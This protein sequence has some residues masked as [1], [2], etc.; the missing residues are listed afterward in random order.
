VLF[1]VKKLQNYVH[2]A[3]HPFEVIRLTNDEGIIRTYNSV[4]KNYT[5]V[6]VDF[7]LSCIIFVVYNFVYC[8]LK[9]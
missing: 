3:G 1:V 6:K 8:L 2:L 5:P 4:G 9:F 7:S